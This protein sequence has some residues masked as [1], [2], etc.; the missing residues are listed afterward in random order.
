MKLHHLGPRQ[1]SALVQIVHVLCDEQKFVGK[2][3]KSGYR[4]VRGIGSRVA[5][6]LAPLTIPLPNQV[7]I[8]RERFRRRQLY[9]I[10]I[11]PVTVFSTERWNPTFSRNT[12][13]CQNENTHAG[14]SISSTEFQVTAVEYSAG[15][16]S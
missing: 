14:R 3:R 10:Q 6:T 15:T 9:R 13:T 12:G 2:L 5:N 11:A 4:F 8:A 1:A 16:D 7:R